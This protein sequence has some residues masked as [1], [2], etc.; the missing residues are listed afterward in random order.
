MNSAR[1]EYL[2]TFSFEPGQ[3]LVLTSGEYDD[4]RIQEVVR[5]LKPVI[6]EQWLPDPARPALALPDHTGVIAKLID[7]GYIGIVSGW[8]EVRVGTID[9]SGC[10]FK[11]RAGW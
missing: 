1:R 3:M 11:E 10:E 7:E 8:N 4:Y 2:K 5:V 6:V 9:G